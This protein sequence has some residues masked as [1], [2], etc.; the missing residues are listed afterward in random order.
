M[1]L[2]LAVH[3]GMWRKPHPEAKNS[4]NHKHHQ[5]NM[6]RNS[7]KDPSAQTIDVWRERCLRVREEKREVLER[8]ER[9]AYERREKEAISLASD[10]LKSNSNSNCWNMHIST[11][12]HDT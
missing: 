1:K 2:F 6:T 7:E 3:I 12:I 10:S 11:Y 8:E 9:G 5:N 4:K